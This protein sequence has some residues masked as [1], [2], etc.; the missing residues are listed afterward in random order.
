MKTLRTILIVI[1]A[2]IAL[3]LI[4]A[5]F[6]KKDYSV[7][8][9]VVINKP[10]ELVFDYVR[11]TANQTHYSK[12]WM[13]DPN[14]QITMTGTDGTPGSVAAWNSKE[15][16]QGEQE[17]TGITEGE[18]IDYELRFIKPFEGK[19][20]SSIMTEAISEDQTKVI[21]SFESSMKYP[22]NIM[23][24][25]MDMPGMLGN[26]LQTSLNTLKT[27]LEQEQSNQQ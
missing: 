11:L 24:V 1:V 6:T 3:L 16:G 22:M 7:Q 25:F 13:M 15:A 14:V 4:I 23:L 12:W 21:W 19:G 20:E 9:E 5:L 17:I 18:R 27:V 10:K 8:R 26:D 2:L